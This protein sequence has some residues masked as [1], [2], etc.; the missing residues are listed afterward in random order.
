[1]VGSLKRRFSEFQLCCCTNFSQPS[2][3]MHKI[4]RDF[5]AKHHEYKS[6]CIYI[7]GLETNK[8]R[9]D[10]VLII[11]AYLL[12]GGRIIGNELIMNVLLNCS[13]V[14]CDFQVMLTLSV[15]FTTIFT[16]SWDFGMIKTNG[17]CFAYS[18]ERIYDKSFFINHNMVVVVVRLDIWSDAL[19]EN[20]IFISAWD[21]HQTIEGNYYYAFHY[22]PKC[23]RQF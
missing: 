13:P 12:P 22:E 9:N 23:E 14:D 2:I 10:S 19:I 21:W 5:Y 15:V 11:C 1:M 4:E 20:A 3:A 16:V 7:Y 8:K 18:D 17:K 6:F